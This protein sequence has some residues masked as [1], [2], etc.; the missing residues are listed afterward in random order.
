MKHEDMSGVEELR[1]A[2]ELFNGCNE[3][4]NDRWSATELLAIARAYRASKWTIEPDEWTERQLR[5]AIHG[6]VPQ[7]DEVEGGLRPV[8]SAPAAPKTG[9]LLWAVH[10]VDGKRVASLKH[11]EDAAALVATMADGSTIRRHRRVLWTEGKEAFPAAESY[12]G[13][14]NVMSE[15]L[16]GK[17]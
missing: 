1:A 17:R 9:T 2:V 16:Q 8:Y 6:Q 5:E 10:N 15:R 12:D 11:A 7:W 3:D 13:V 14:A 4:S